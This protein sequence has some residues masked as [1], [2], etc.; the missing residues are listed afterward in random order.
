MSN[1]KVIEGLFRAHYQGMYRLAR[2]IL[3]DG[4]AARDVVHD[5]F[6]GLLS[7]GKGAEVSGGYLI[8][9]VRNRCLNRLR[10]LSIHERAANL[11]FLEMREYDDEAWPD[12]AT[13]ARIYDIIKN[14]LTSQG[15]RVMELRFE[16]GMSFSKIADVLGV[17]EN[18]V[19]KHVRHALV[20]IRKNLNDNG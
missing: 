16:A 7:S 4:D 1:V 8:W 13:V 10:D 14:D 6:A 17:S 11:Y 19:Y 9:A 3:R 15:R 12:E 18:A 5:V 20:I 2:G